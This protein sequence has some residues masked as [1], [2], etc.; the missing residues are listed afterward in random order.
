M[1]RAEKLT[2]QAKPNN[3]GPCT[4]LW[5]TTT[6]SD[7][8]ISNTLQGSIIYSEISRSRTTSFVFPVTSFVHNHQQSL[9]QELR[10][11]FTAVCREYFRFVSA[12]ELV[13][14]QMTTPASCSC[15]TKYCCHAINSLLHTSKVPSSLGS[16][17]QL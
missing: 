14:A 17:V 9:Q 4:G 5:P 1:G 11:C 12:V 7:K 15:R 16:S 10:I 3:S 13:N 6:I 2:S 8:Q